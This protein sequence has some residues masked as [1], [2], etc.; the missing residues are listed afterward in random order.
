MP[1]TIT[2]TSTSKSTTRERIK[3]CSHD[4][5]SNLPTIEKT[6]IAVRLSVNNK[7]CQISSFTSFLHSLVVGVV[8]VTMEDGTTVVE[9]TG[10]EREGVR[11]GVE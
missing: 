5:V 4:H 8:G 11:E 10:M 1:T 6:I 2:I 7:I 9:R 3:K